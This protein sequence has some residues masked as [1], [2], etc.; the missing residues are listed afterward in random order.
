MRTR[1]VVDL[2][3][4]PDGR[5]D[6]SQWHTRTTL[7]G[8]V[9]DFARLR[10]GSR[11]LEPS[12]GVGRLAVMVPRTCSLTTIEID[13]RLV[14]HLRARGQAR[15]WEVIC[16]DFLEWA[17][18]PAPPHRKFDV[19]LSNPP[20]ENDQDGAHVLAALAVCHRLVA[21]VRAQFLFG[22]GR[23][24]AIWQWYSYSRIAVLEQRPPFDGVTAK[25]A[26]GPRH[27]FLVVEIVPRLPAEIGRSTDLVEIERWP[28]RW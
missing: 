2:A 17:H 7:A 5:K 15:G 24:E 13:P 4:I 22:V 23:S 8:R 21:I 6:L 27:D 26:D 20:F 9:A 12:A 14:A 1:G 10:P 18:R 28:D 16:A 11:V 3:T 19:G 25:T